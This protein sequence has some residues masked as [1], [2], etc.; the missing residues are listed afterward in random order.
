[1]LPEK[2]R[3]F[4]LIADRADMRV[5]LAA[6]LGRI[7]ADKQTIDRMDTIVREGAGDVLV[8]NDDDELVLLRQK[9]E[10]GQPVYYLVT[11]EAWLVHVDPSA[12]SRIQ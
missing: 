4:L 1:M 11:K 5:I 12:A 7:G 10:L 3:N 6:E 2:D 8:S 9:D